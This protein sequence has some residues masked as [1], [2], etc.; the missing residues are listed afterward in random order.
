MQAIDIQVYVTIVC[1]ALVTYALRIGG[2]LLAERLPSRGRFK[3][4]MDALPGTLLIALISPG[5]A[6]SGLLGGVASL[7]TAGVAYRSGNVFWAM[8]TGVGVVALGRQLL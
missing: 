4:F 2:L 6:A 5:I 7:L 1:A 3:T 8:L